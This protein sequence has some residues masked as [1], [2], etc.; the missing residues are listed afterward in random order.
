MIQD[1]KH[2]WLAFGSAALV[3]TFLAVCGGCNPCVPSRCTSGALMTI[4]ITS[5]AASLAGTTVTVCRNAECYTATLPDV[6]V[7]GGGGTGLFFS[8]TTFVL[9][10]LWQNAS[11]S[12]GLDLEWHLDSS[13]LQDGDH[14][15]VT[16]TNAAGVVTPVLDKT[17]TYTQ[18]PPSPEECAGGATCSI[19]NLTN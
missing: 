7:A 5:S 1:H 19:A 2:R 16:F 6:P 11:G 15:V 9:G 4:P 17:A 3:A 12:I 13:Q 14:Y 8:G 18:L 10:T